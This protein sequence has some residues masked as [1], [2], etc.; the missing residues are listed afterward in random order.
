MLGI[1][2]FKKLQGIFIHWIL[3]GTVI[4][5]II[6]SELMEA[7]WEKQNMY[8]PFVFKQN[9]LSHLIPWIFM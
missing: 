6:V 9:K 1:K 5:Y 3:P 4:Y 2:C 7:L 8:P